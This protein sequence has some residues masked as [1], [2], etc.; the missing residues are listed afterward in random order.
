[1]VWLLVMFTVVMKDHGSMNPKHDKQC[2]DVAIETMEYRRSDYKMA[3]L[4]LRHGCV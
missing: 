3:Q 2:V 4:A 1:M